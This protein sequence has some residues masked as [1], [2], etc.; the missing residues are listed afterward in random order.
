M[1]S[2]IINVI[3]KCGSFYNVLINMMDILSTWDFFHCV[4]YII[5]LTGHKQEA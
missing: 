2:I 1:I 4:G 3:I 5:C